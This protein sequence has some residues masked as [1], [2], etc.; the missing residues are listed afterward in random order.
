M[1]KSVYV[2]C[3][4]NLKN[5]MLYYINGVNFPRNDLKETGEIR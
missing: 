3:K 4:L 5:S 2:V 1:S